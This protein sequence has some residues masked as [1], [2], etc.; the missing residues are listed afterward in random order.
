LNAHDFVWIL[1]VIVAVA[2]LVG[3]SFVVKDVHWW[4][5][6]YTWGFKVPEGTLGAVIPGK[7]VLAGIGNGIVL[8]LSRS[9]PSKSCAK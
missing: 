3:Q 1:M 2:Y 5:S 4:D 8:A 9:K 7:A 6:G